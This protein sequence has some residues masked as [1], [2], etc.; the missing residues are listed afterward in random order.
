MVVDSLIKGGKER[1]LVEL[2]NGFRDTPTIH[3]LLVLLKDTIDYPEVYSIPGVEVKVLNRRIKKDPAVIFSLYN[4]SKKFEPEIIHS[5]G[6]T[7]SIYAVLVAKFMGIRFINAMITN[8]IC[9]K[10]SKNWLAAR[11]TF[12]FSDKVLS[13]SIAGLIAY[14]APKQKSNVVYNGFNFS[15]I[16]KI[17]SP[18]E[19]KRKFGLKT[20]YVVGMVGVFTEKK[21]FETFVYSAMKILEDQSDITFLAIGGGPNLE[22]TKK[23]I[24]PKFR[25]KILLLGNQDDVESI[26]NIFD[27]GILTSNYKFAREGISNSIMEYMAFGKPVIAT[28]GGGTNEI[29]LDNETGFIIESG[30]I[31]QLVESIEYLLG[32]P[33]EAK[34]MGQ[35]GRQRVNNVFS[36]DNMVNGTIEIYNDLET[37]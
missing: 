36:I 7:P 32:N 29:V 3:V 27:I 14:N 19:V 31:K 23:F 1:R 2:L 18:D 5:W 4:L 6:A 26:V 17:L 25:D 34:L 11:L 35:K 33:A 8:A 9:K 30:S 22:K 28:R 13:N 10:G 16:K 20:K 21:D 12:P 24:L 37:K 15:R